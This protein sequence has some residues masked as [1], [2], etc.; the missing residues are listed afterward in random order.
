MPLLNIMDILFLGERV[1]L[2]TNENPKVHSPL[3]LRP[4]AYLRGILISQTNRV[5]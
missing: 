4:V 3:S 1:S 2:L 5:R